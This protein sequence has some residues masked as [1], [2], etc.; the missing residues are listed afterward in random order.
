[1]KLIIQCSLDDISTTATTSPHEN[2]IASFIAK[3]R[4]IRT[5]FGLLEVFDIILSPI[6]IILTFSEYFAHDNHL[7]VTSQSDLCGEF[8]TYLFIHQRFEYFS[9]GYTLTTVSVLCSIPNLYLNYLEI[10]RTETVVAN[11]EKFSRKMHLY[12]IFSKAL[13]TGN[14][15]LIVLLRGA[16]LAGIPFALFFIGIFNTAFSIYRLVFREIKGSSCCGQ[17]CRR[18]W[19]MLLYPLLAVVTLLATLMFVLY[20]LMKREH[21]CVTE[22]ISGKKRLEYECNFDSISCDINMCNSTTYP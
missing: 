5:E 15:F 20:V 9:I 19:R 7:C 8:F 3:L 21:I 22:E 16:S 12:D 1:M 13:F 14:Q 17:C 2:N 18:L 10:I 6:L 4:I 11:K